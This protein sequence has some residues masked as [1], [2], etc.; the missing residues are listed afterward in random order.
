ML[1]RWLLVLERVLEGGQHN[2]SLGWA[3]V[4]D[5]CVGPLAGSQ[6]KSKML[7]GK[8]IVQSIAELL[9]EGPYS[10]LF[11]C[12]AE[13]STVRIMIRRINRS[14]VVLRLL[15]PTLPM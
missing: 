3:R 1:G 10:F 8:D 9:R 12:F 11:R 6:N 15:C 5:V 13:R 4:R 2:I 14:A 7:T